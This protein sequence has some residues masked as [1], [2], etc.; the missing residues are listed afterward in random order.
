MVGKWYQ[1][2]CGG[3]TAAG[4][5]REGTGVREAVSSIAV[6]EGV[7]RGKPESA[8]AGDD[9]VEDG[10]CGIPRGNL[11]MDPP[12]PRRGRV[13]A[14]GRKRGGPVEKLFGES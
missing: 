12:P 13:S 3:P 1:S 14:G 5:G 7:T 10:M 11:G 8:K 2:G 9:G 6:V 4:V